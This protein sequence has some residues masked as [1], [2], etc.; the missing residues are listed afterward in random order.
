MR[1]LGGPRLAEP[2]EMRAM[3]QRLTAA[4]ENNSTDSRRVFLGRRD[5]RPVERLAVANL[6]HAI[7]RA[8]RP[9]VFSI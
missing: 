4:F 2:A 3:N 9:K 1:F 6:L 5:W 7:G 8:P